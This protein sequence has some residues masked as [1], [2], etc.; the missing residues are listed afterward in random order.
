MAKK[1][2]LSVSANTIYTKKYESFRGVDF[3]KDEF[4]VDDEH[5]PYAKNLISDTDG[6]PE[7]RVGWRTL[8]NFGERINGVYIPATEIPEKHL[9]WYDDER[10]DWQRGFNA[11]WDQIIGD[12][13]FIYEDI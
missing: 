12:R 7:K 4:M 10:S 13:E 6:F 11:C 8:K 1:S 3:S 2:K 5:S 9:V